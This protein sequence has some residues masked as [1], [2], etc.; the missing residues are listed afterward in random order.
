M[1]SSL[2]ALL[3][4]STANT[5]TAKQ[6][7]R[8]LHMPSLGESLG[9]YFDRRDRVVPRCRNDSVHSF[10][11]AYQVVAHYNYNKVGNEY[12]DEDAR[13]SLSSAAR[14]SCMPWDFKREPESSRADANK[15]ARCYVPSFAP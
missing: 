1:A 3:S 2:V 11:M 8:L 15:N 5:A 10:E 4:D 12:D 7:A 13:A 9:A 14:A 6:V